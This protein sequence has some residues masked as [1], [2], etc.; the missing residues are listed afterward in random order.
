MELQMVGKGCA[1]SV[2]PGAVETDALHAIRGYVAENEGYPY[3]EALERPGGGL[4]IRGGPLGAPD[5]QV[6]SVR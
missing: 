2:A 4:W 6:R 5:N 1:N 3:E